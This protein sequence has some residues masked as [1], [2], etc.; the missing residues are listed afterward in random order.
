MFSKVCHS[1]SLFF[2]AGFAVFTAT[3]QDE[4][5]PLTIDSNLVVLNVS[6]RDTRGLHVSGLKQKSFSVLEDGI[7][8]PISF[9]AAEETPYAAVIL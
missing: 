9:F 2:F 4:D 8:P 7:D 5:T 3:A 1:A 6:V